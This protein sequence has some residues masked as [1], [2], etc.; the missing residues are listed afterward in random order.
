LG[1]PNACLGRD[2]PRFGQE[3]LQNQ[4]GRPGAVRPRTI[5]VKTVPKKVS[6]NLAKIEDYAIN[7]SRTLVDRIR[8]LYGVRDILA[9]LKSVNGTVG[10]IGTLDDDVADAVRDSL[11]KLMAKH[12]NELQ[13]NEAINSLAKISLTDEAAKAVRDMA[14]FIGPGPCSGVQNL[15]KDSLRLQTEDQVKPEVDK[16]LSDIPKLHAE[17]GKRAAR[18][19]KQVRKKKKRIIK[20]G[21]PC[22]VKGAKRRTFK[23]LAICG[24]RSFRTKVDPKKVMDNMNKLTAADDRYADLEKIGL[25]SLQG[26]RAFFLALNS[27]EFVN[28]LTS[29]V[30]THDQAV[31]IKNCLKDD[32]IEGM[33]NILESREKNSK[34]NL[35]ASHLCPENISV[36]L[37][38]FSR[39]D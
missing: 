38:R 5:R 33:K 9:A 12:V 32:A 8:L 27:P 31:T 36:C 3:E 35:G 30:A 21:T 29:T 18:I 4:L 1:I 25:F 17:L 39:L 2:I 37:T 19:R 13:K 20:T 16:A 6:E 7:A 15:S 22:K 14:S 24:A 34:D 23:D 11:K 10:S 26:I 28:S